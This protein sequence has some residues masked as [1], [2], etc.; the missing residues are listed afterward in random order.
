MPRANPDSARRLPDWL[1][2]AMWAA[3]ACLLIG[4]IGVAVFLLAVKMD[5]FSEK[6]LTDEQSKAVW[7][8]VGVSLGAVVT[9]IGTLLAEQ[10]NRRTAALERE[11]ETR[12]RLD[13]VGRLLELLTEDGEYAKPAR[14][15]GAIATMV[16]LEG[17]SVAL[18]VLGEL[19]AARAVDP[20]TAV[21]L[22]EQVLNEDWP[23]DDQV[24]AAALLAL[25]ATTLVPAEGDREQD[26][27]IWPSLPK[28][29]PTAAPDG[30]KNALILL[31]PRVLLARE[32]KYWEERAGNLTP[33]RML[34][35]A[36]HDKDGDY[37]N[38]AS[39]ILLVLTE[40]GVL[41]AVGVQLEEDV[42]NMSDH[43][44]AAVEAGSPSFAELLSQLRSWGADDGGGRRP[45]PLTRNDA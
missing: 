13:T 29:W 39:A 35:D 9:L 42:K 11:A 16:E 31:A 41:E 34:A 24:F 19:W 22:I 40:A 33:F 36:L 18:R 44:K 10:H 25:N 17:G 4:L 38:R 6:A 43:A 12:L 28:R 26:W 5:F 45:P 14:V 3:L 32:R 15:G 7:T 23:E 1:V 30:V 27:E 2:V 37:R 20:V 21:W 8:F